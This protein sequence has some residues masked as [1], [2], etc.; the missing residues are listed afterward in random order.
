[1][2]PTDIANRFSNDNNFLVSKIMWYMFVTYSCSY[3]CSLV[4]CQVNYPA[5][6][7]VNFL[8]KNQLI[9]QVNICFLTSFEQ[10][11]DDGNYIRY[12]GVKICKLDFT[13]GDNESQ[14]KSATV[15]YAILHMHRN[16]LSSY[17]VCSI[18]SQKY[19]T[20]QHTRFEVNPSDVFTKN[21]VT[22]ASVIT[23]STQ[24]S[25]MPEIL[26]L[27]FSTIV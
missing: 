4:N 10:M 9:H 6:N 8:M 24:S 2:Q 20:L 1:M 19:F 27:S 3:H 12:L 25:T 22:I 16:I 18:I 7:Q 17:F 5:K 15:P 23:S 21:W 14:V 13:F 11:I 26:V